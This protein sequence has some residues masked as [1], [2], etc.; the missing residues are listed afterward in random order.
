M[1]GLMEPHIEYARAKDGVSI[2]IKGASER[3]RPW[4]VAY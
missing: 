2:A 3:W 1:A 4:E